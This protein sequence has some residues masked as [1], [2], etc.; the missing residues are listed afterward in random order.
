MDN[1]NNSQSIHINLFN[2]QKNPKRKTPN[3]KR[4]NRHSSINIYDFNNNTTNI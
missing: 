1:T 4:K 2:S 3:Y